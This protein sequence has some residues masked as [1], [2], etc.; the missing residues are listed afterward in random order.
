[1]AI[2]GHQTLD[3]ALTPMQILNTVSSSVP[4][5]LHF[6]ADRDSALFVSNLQD[7]NN[8]GIRIH[9]SDL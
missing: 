3:I 4:D 5:P 1:M 8:R 7:T 9:T 2:F 6:D